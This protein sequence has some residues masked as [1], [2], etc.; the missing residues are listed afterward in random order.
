MPRV[1]YVAKKHCRRFGIV[2]LAFTLKKEND[3][4]VILACA[5]TPDQDLLLLDLHRE[6]M[7]GPEIVPA[8]ESMGHKHNLSYFGVE[9]VQAQLLVCQLLRKRGWVIR[10]LKA[11]VDKLS[12]AIPA[13]VRYESGQVFLPEGGYWVDEYLNE[14]LA[15]PRGTHDDQVD[16]TSYAAVEVQRFGGAAE[17]DSLTALREY[18]ETELAAEFFMRADNPDF[19]SGDDD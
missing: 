2:D 1:K 4:T 6:R 11:D 7:E 18:A 17:P 10:E 5:V 13:T 9:S 16:V 15:F 19:W 8:I 14:L 3:Y 12:R